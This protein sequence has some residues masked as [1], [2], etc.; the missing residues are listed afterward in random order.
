MNARS[1]KKTKTKTRGLPSC[2]GAG[3]ALSALV[4]LMLHASPSRLALPA[5]AGSAA[6][7]GGPKTVR[8]ISPSRMV[9]NRN[10]R[11]WKGSRRLKS[12]RITR[13]RH[14]RRRL[15][16]RC[17]NFRNG[18]GGDVRRTPSFT[19][20]FFSLPSSTSQCIPV[21][22]NELACTPTSPHPRNL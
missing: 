20:A 19:S 1:A 9:R 21:S 17:D 3:P 10:S 5:R 16:S 22:V 11:G 6:L 4:H 12:N 18:G 8:I 2:Q 7:W 13:G 14:H 15:P